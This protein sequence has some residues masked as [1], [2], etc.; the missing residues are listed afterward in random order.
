MSASTLPPIMGTYGRFPIT[1]VEGKGTE[2]F[3][4]KGQRYLDFLGGISVLPLGHAP[5]A[6]LKTL[7]EQANKLW[8]VSNLYHIQPQQDLAQKLVDSSCFDQVFFCNSGTEAV[9]AALKLARISSEKSHGKSRSTFVAM[10]KSFHGRS[11][12]S[13][14]VTGQES[15]QAPFRPLVPEVRFADFGDIA[16]LKEQMADDVAAVI[17]EPMQAEG[18]LNMPPEGYLAEVRKICDEHGALLI[19]DEV[20]V[21]IGRLGSLFAYQLFGVE[22]DIMTLAKGLGG[23]F[24]IG[25]CLA[26]AEISQHFVPGTHA[27]TFGG[28]PLASATAL[29][30]LN[31]IED[32]DVIEKSQAK[33]K[34]IEDFMAKACA[35]IDGA[36]EP[37]GKGML[38]GIRFDKPVLPLLN[39]CLEAGL[40]VG[41]AGPNTLRIAPALNTPDDL[42]EEGLN[43]LFTCIEKFSS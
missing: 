39:H 30:V 36:L 33:A 6:P 43:V 13:L 5:D 29:A 3:D 31:A 1:L 37:R 25:A 23:G 41:M 38:Q 14:S 35:K 24:P 34:T 11:F 21:G 28:N 22:P 2:V 12:G 4:D 40:L 10:N 26:K 16:S 18:G 15:Y 7:I 19:Y 9:E 20:Q 27:S 42:L 17:M 32:G 8:H